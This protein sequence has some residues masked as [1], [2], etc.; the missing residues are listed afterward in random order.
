MKERIY[1]IVAIV[2]CIVSILCL[3]QIKRLNNELQNLDRN[4]NNQISAVN[5]SVN[6][7]YGNIDSLLEKQASILSDFGYEYGKADYKN[8]IITTHFYISPKEYASEQTKALLSVNGREYDMTYENGTYCVDIDLPLY[9][10][11]YDST[12]Y[13]YDNGTVRTERVDFCVYPQYDVIPYVYSSFGGSNSING[14]KYNVSGPVDIDINVGDVSAMPEIINAYIIETVN[15]EIVN[16]EKVNP[17]YDHS[18]GNYIHG[19]VDI[20]K[21][22]EA[23]DG[24]SYGLYIALEDSNVYYVVMLDGFKIEGN[25]VAHRELY[26]DADIYSKDGRLLLRGNNR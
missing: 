24:N 14:N 23:E 4:M 3:F 25:N 16:K 19:Q 7:I 18:D 5:S 26:S 20:Q 17:E 12:V 8:G 2:S 1:R 11:S 15:G 21:S 9:D 13:F 22:I 6:S 10:N